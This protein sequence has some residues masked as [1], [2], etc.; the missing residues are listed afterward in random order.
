MLTLDYA[1]GHV[2]APFE[3]TPDDQGVVNDLTVSRPEGGAARRIVTGGPRGV[4]M[5]GRY[6]RSLSVNVAGDYQLAP[7]AAWAVHFGT[8]D[9]DRFPVIRLNLRMLAGRAGGASLVSDAVDLV[10]G[11]RVVV[12]N[13]P[14]WMPADDVD[15][16]V[17][18]YSESIT[19][20]E[21]VIDEH[22]T[23]AGPLRVGE[24]ADETPDSDDPPEPARYSPEDSQTVRPFAAGSD[25]ELLVWDGTGGHD[26]WTTDAGAY[27]FDLLASGVRLRATVAA[28]VAFDA[29]GRTE[30][31][32]WGTSDSGHTWVPQ[33]TV[34]TVSV[35]GG[36][37]HITTTGTSYETLTALDLA[38]VEVLVAV[39]IGAGGAGHIGLVLRVDN[40]D[41]T[42]NYGVTIN[43]DQTR[44]D[45]YRNSGGS[46][47]LDNAAL[48]GW[49]T[50]TPWWIRARI[51]GSLFQAR[52]WPVGG[53]EPGVWMVSA[54]DSTH[55]SGSVGCQRVTGGN[56]VAGSFADFQIV[57]PQVLTVAQAPVNG[58]TKTIPAGS[59]V[60]LWRPARYAL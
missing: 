6:E 22:T 2:S 30:A 35:S 39:E 17:L 32:T 59:K 19:R 33:R 20:Q 24:W 43:A 15:Q 50:Q 21:W 27:P 44:L 48:S 28:S 41:P 23:P 9:E 36:R 57:N 47:L 38:D 49:A 11:D 34:A 54:E 10:E 37:G 53:P 55:T 40:N 58:V 26:L 16:L 18:G 60:E 7:I 29:F 14:E 56:D 8:W 1:A 4:D 13:P 52:A 12:K 46:S 45:L 3:P 42:E 31:G 51:V 25:T 5:V